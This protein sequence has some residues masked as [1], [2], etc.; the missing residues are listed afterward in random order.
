MLVKLY[1]N[2]KNLK[3]EERARNLYSCIKWLRSWFLLLNQTITWKKHDPRDL[4]LLL[5]K[6]KNTRQLTSSKNKWRTIQSVLT[7]H[8]AK[9]INSQ[10][11]LCK[12]PNWLEPSR[13]LSCVPLDISQNLV[14]TTYPYRYSYRNQWSF[15]SGFLYSYRTNH[16]AMYI[17]SNYSKASRYFM[18]LETRLLTLPL[19]SIV[20]ITRVTN[21]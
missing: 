7:F 3:R 19:V 4:S 10:I 2:N 9:H 13:R 14:T 6:L 1:K 20:A 11:I 16:P 18:V 21:V 17:N 12:N 5:K 8:Q 15:K